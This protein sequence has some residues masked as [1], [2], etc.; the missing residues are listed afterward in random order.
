MFKKSY[1]KRFF[2]IAALFVTL[3][4]CLSVAACTSAADQTKAAVPAIV[5]PAP[6]PT[7]GA[8]GAAA[9]V[10]PAPGPSFSYDFI[11]RLTEGGT[12]LV[13]EVPASDKKQAYLAQINGTL[14]IRWV[15]C[16]EFLSDDDI[17]KIFGAIP[18]VN[19][20]TDTV[21]PDG[22]PSG[23]DPE[24]LLETGK[25]PGLG[26]R[27]LHEQDI[28]GKGVSIAIID[29]TLFT[30]HPEY[31]DNLVLYEEIHVQANEKADMHGSAVS[32][33]AVGKTCGVAP[34]AKL[35]Y[36]AVNLAKDVYIPSSADENIAFAEGLAA[37]VDRLLAVNAALP[38]REKIKV[39]S[40]SRG[41]SDLEDAGVRVFLEAVE[42]AKDA[43]IF[44]ITTSTFRYSD[45]MT[46]ETDFGG[47]GK[48]DMSG[49]PDSL[50]TYTLGSWE[51][52][53][54][55][56]FI[57]KLLVPMD[58]RT[59][60]D[61]TGEDDYVFYP[62]GG[63]SWVAP[64][65]AGLYALGVQVNPDITPALFWTT[66]LSTARPLTVTINDS[67]YTFSHVIDPTSLLEAL[68]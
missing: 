22:L 56:Y 55:A 32:S 19:F 64:Y 16:P 9:S 6:S 38:E 29:Q 49:D 3:A 40:I 1:P 47:L 2:R 65:L 51:Q 62:Q 68:S 18:Y 36:W 33:I 42:R 30:G 67:S 60:A 27:A 8:G 20:N 43:G 5:T 23:F 63:W 48:A 13:R 24:A 58:G 39:L 28:T 31:K 44:V 59:T 17:Q 34:G 15:D 26:V 21:W 52:A 66:A 50:S 14:D 41:F 45:F 12:G 46:E 10:T 37:A 53:G 61:F 25:N 7:P 11:T 35:Y 54:A 57:D 4:L